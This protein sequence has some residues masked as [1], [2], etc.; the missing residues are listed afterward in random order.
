MVKDAPDHISM[1]MIGLSQTSSKILKDSDILI[2]PVIV[3]T[4]KSFQPSVSTKPLL[5]NIT[6]SNFCVEVNTTRIWLYIQCQ[7]TTSD[8]KIESFGC[9]LVLKEIFEISI[10]IKQPWSKLNF[11]FNSWKIHV[12]NED[13]YKILYVLQIYDKNNHR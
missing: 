6:L 8:K 9:S 13:I 12:Q 10:K 5:I 1:N 7:H 2:F 3:I 11:E 4:T